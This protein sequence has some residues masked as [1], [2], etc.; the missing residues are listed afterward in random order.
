ME[1][2]MYKKKAPKGI[3]IHRISQSKKYP[4]KKVI[5]QRQLTMVI[6][7]AM[8]AKPKKIKT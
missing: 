6:T 7:Q 5:S 1:R 4:T 8:K 3:M 2:Y